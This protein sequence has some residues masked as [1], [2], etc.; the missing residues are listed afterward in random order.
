MGFFKPE[1]GRKNVYEKNPKGEFM[2]CLPP[3]NVTGKLHLG[4]ALT[5]TVEDVLTR[6][7]R[8][9]GETT[10][11]NP[12]CDHAGIATQVVVERKLK[13]ERNISRH[14]IGREAFLKEVWKWKEEKGSSIYEQLRSLGSSL[15]WDRAFFTMDDKLTR[16]V[17]EVFVRL[18]EQG[19]I[20]RSTRL[21]NWS[22][23]LKSAISDIEVDKR[24]LPG[25]TLLNVPG[26]D[27]K[28]E[29]GVLVS[30]AYPIVD[31][32][33]GEEIIVATTRL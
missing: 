32:K 17:K 16:A 18:H 5:N 26:Y 28:I 21:I 2:M 14:D 6:W 1:Y 25:R 8:M 9:R 30:F 7:R 19:L 10:L 24:E 33:P 31:G 12:G 20:F 29:F 4:H 11:W 23:T 22:C 15:D 3:P 13:R 27:D